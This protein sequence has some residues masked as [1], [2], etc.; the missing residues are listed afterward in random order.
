MLISGFFSYLGFHQQDLCCIQLETK[1]LSH[2]IGTQ[3]K[4]QTPISRAAWSWCWKREH[5][6]SWDQINCITFHSIIMPT[7]NNQFKNCVTFVS[8][9]YLPLLY[10]RRYPYSLIDIF[11]LFSRTV[12]IFYFQYFFLAAH[13]SYRLQ[14]IY[15]CA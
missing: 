10:A 9:L 5:M 8:N 12:N 13:F 1:S 11:R 6:I 14:Y 2:L 15:E 7:Y 4:E 3:L